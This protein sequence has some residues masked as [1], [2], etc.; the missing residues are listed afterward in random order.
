[1]LIYDLLLQ[2][3]FHQVKWSVEG[4]GLANLK[5]SSVGDCVEIFLKIVA[6]R[7]KSLRILENEIFTHQ[8][9]HF[10]CKNPTKFPDIF[11]KNVILIVDT[12]C[13][14]NLWNRWRSEWEKKY[15]MHSF[16]WRQVQLE[17]IYLQA[18]IYFSKRL[19]LSARIFGPGV[20]TTKLFEIQTPQRN[21]WHFDCRNFL[22]FFE[23]CC[24]KEGWENWIKEVSLRLL[25]AFGH[26]WWRERCLKVFIRRLLRRNF[27]QNWI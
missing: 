8:T 22:R 5:R 14:I 27:G 20:V 16:T 25:K 17:T 3:I 23:A 4:I 9:G 6:R 18:D 11:T 12:I 19:I 21:F 1:M 24:L 2:I 7:V 15:L 13:I 26:Y 10:E